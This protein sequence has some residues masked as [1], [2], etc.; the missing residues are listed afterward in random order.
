MVSSISLLIRTC[1]P[2]SKR[3]NKMGCH[4]RKR[5]AK[6]EVC[7]VVQGAP[8]KTQGR[9]T[10]EDK[11]RVQGISSSAFR[12]PSWVGEDEELGMAAVFLS[13]DNKICAGVAWES[14]PSAQGSSNGLREARVRTLALELGVLSRS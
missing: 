10:V 1:L 4:G 7:D 6:S 3:L 5:K 2:L 8:K 13:Q 14:S 11:A 9:R 12:S